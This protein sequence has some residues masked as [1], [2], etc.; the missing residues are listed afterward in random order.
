MNVNHY[1]S[2]R[3]VCFFSTVP[4][5]RLKFENYSIQDIRILEELGFTVI[6][7][8]K[9]S[10]IP[11]GCDLYFSWW[12]SGSIFPL[13]KA[14]LSARPIV[15]I[16]GGNESMIYMDSIFRI[17][18]GY[19]G[20]PLHKKLATR[21]V[22]RFATIVLPVSNFMINSIRKLGVSTFSVVHNCVDT[23]L[24]VPRVENRVYITSIFRTDRDVVRIKRGEVFIYAINEVVR[25]YPSQKF[26]IIGRA[27]NDY[28]RLNKLI[29]NLAL[30]NNI[31]FVEE[32]ENSIIIS[33][34]HQ[35]SLYVQISDTETFGVSIAEAMSCE[36]PVLVSKSG[37]IPEIVGP[38][39]LY[40]DHNSPASVAAGIIKFL[41]MDESETRRIGKAL[42]AR[43]IE[44]FSFT[45]RK[46]KIF[47][48]LQKILNV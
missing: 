31:V 48:I 9:F 22:L 44:N 6:I 20:N 4:K 46:K 28:E 16:A 25:S 8:S 32:V 33:L 13:I 45:N 24:Y 14:F 23:N 10:E 11:F 19:V 15:V 26:M 21:L 36:I 34:L 47:Q 18:A 40:V 1:F 3:T 30:Q 43:I 7:A 41:K 17:P 12:A 2:K 29:E 35:S 5:E 38:F 42:R 37:A 27:G 39:G